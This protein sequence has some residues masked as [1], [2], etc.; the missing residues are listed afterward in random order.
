MQGQKEVFLYP[1]LFVHTKNSWPCS[2]E[3]QTRN[4]A[5][6]SGKIR[7]ELNLQET[8]TTDFFKVWK[9]LGSFFPLTGIE[10]TSNLQ[11]V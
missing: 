11:L 9:S 3:I 8:Q 5:S 1:V 10:C 7:T 6:L 4:E 2:E